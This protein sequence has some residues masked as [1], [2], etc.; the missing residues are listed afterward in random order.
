MDLSFELFRLRVV[1]KALSDYWDWLLFGGFDLPIL[2][3]CLFI[4]LLP[5]E[6]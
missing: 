2:L 5:V 1:T 3:D 6:V 4:D